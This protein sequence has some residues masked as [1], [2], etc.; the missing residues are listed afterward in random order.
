MPN[1]SA[2][3]IWFNNG[4]AMIG[5]G[6]PN[7]KLQVNGNISIL[8]STTESRLKI[9]GSSGT[10][11]RLWIE[12]QDPSKFGMISWFVGSSQKWQMGYNGRYG[13]GGWYL[14]NVSTGKYAILV[15]SK[16]NFIGIGTTSPKSELHVEGTILAREIK[17]EAQ[18]ADFVFE[19]D[20]YLR[21][22]EEVESF[23]LENKHLPEIPN[24]AQME[25]DGT[26]LAEMNKLL[27]MKIEELTLYMIEQQKMILELKGAISR[28]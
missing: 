26:N 27:L 19:E 11:S 20:Y 17:V 22:L 7:E 5:D 25:A 12:V 28:E 13:D 15:N 1:V 8:N 16:D 6:I 14:Y 24:A 23:I 21:P 9:I 18:T 4:K 10:N 3:P 2:N